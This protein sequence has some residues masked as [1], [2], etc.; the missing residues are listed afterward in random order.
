MLARAVPEQLTKSIKQALFPLFQEVGLHFDKER[1][2]AII[3]V[4]PG[5]PHIIDAIQQS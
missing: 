3:A 1:E 4:H 5:G 2:S